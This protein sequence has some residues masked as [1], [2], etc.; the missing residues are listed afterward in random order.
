MEITPFALNG[1][2]QVWKR[3]YLFS[4]FVETQQRHGWLGGKGDPEFIFQTCFTLHGKY[5]EI[6]TQVKLYKV[7]TLMQSSLK[8]DEVAVDHLSDL[9]GL[10]I[11]E[12]Y[13]K[14]SW[15]RDL[16]IPHLRSQCMKE[17]VVL[18][19][20]KGKEVD[21]IYLGLSK[22]LPDLRELPT[23][24][25]LMIEYLPLMNVIFKGISLHISWR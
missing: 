1:L 14:I 16:S 6:K 23:V 8:G 15:I 13:D 12:W 3:Y 21:T 10:P 2:L 18:L 17:E 22:H 7:F 9:L 25:R 4:N 11:P 5:R 20:S 19:N 24:R